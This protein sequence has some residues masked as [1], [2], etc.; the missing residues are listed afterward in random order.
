[1]DMPFQIPEALMPAVIGAGLW[2]GGCFLFLAPELTTRAIDLHIAK[3]C[4]TGE[5]PDLCACMLGDIQTGSGVYKNALFLSTFS[6]S[7]PRVDLLGNTRNPYIEYISLEARNTK[8]IH[9]CGKLRIDNTL[10]NTPSLSDTIKQAQIKAKEEAERKAKQERE[11]LQQ[12][13]ARELEK[14]QQANL[15]RLEE[16][17]KKLSQLTDAAQNSPLGEEA[18]KKLEQAKRAYILQ[19][20]AADVFLNW[21][22]TLVESAERARQDYVRN[23]Q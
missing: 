14:Q 21:G 6:L 8:R 15:Q 7:D 3:E 17:E 5:T 18:R 4:S 11:R 13:H 20:K 22:E 2:Y 1:M 19:D 12:Q 10:P 9:A 23:R 16:A